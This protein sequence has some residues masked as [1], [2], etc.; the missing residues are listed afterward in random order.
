EQ[1]AAFIDKH[2]PLPT[3]PP[4]AFKEQRVDV[5]NLGD[6]AVMLHLPDHQTLYPHEAVAIRQ[7]SGPDG[8][9][10]TPDATGDVLLLG[11]SYTNIYSLPEM[12]WG[13]AAGLAEHL[14]LVLQ[15]PVDR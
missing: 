15:R 3:R 13:A 11:D 14:A 10:W 1:L 8:R 12:K 2:C 4:G 7:I 5:E 9:D 6:I